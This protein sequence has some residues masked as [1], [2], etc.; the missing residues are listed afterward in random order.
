MGTV[1]LGIFPL[2]G[3]LIRAVNMSHLLYYHAGLQIMALILMLLGSGLGIY[4]GQANYPVC[5]KDFKM[6]PNL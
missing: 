2:A 5:E 1:F 4:Y 3:M 6:L